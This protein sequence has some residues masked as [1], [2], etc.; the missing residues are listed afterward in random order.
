M[1]SKLS[2]I[3]FDLAEK[4]RTK[5]VLT[6]HRFTQLLGQHERRLILNA[7]ITAKL[8]RREIKALDFAIG[9]PKPHRAAINKPIATIA[10]SLLISMSLRR[11]S[12]WAP[13]LV[14]L[15]HNSAETTM[16]H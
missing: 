13:A 1:A 5:D 11:D 4:L 6:V 2:T 8:E 10:I 15:L 9:V 7:K 12:L 16:W 14:C 3:D